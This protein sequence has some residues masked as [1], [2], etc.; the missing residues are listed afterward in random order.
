MAACSELGLIGTI[1]ENDDIKIAPESSDSDEETVRKYACHLYL[2]F[3]IIYP[4][5]PH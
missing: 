2:K 5:Y 1:T 3:L 4:N